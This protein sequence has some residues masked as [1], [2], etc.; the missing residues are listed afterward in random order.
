MVTL[1]GHPSGSS[2][3]EKACG[4]AR[5][6]EALVAVQAEEPHEALLALRALRPQAPLTAMSWTP[7][8]RHCAECGGRL[9]VRM[10]E[11]TD[12]WP[13]WTGTGNK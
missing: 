12:M 10:R 8:L 6:R 5:S 4:C 7:P 13:S 1:L 2:C 9:G 3:D 11:E